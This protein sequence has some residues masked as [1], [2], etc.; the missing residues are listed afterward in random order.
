MIKMFPH[1]S[2]LKGLIMIATHKL[3]YF[4]IDEK[5]YY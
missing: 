4:A 3:S 5:I 1:K 2:I